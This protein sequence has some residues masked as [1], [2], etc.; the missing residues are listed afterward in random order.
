MSDQNDQFE[1]LYQRGSLDS[2]DRDRVWAEALRR[3][4]AGDSAASPAPAGRHAGLDGGPQ[5]AFGRPLR[6]R[7]AL[8]AGG[9]VA[10]AA[11]A[12]AAALVFA[13]IQP[14]AAVD[15]TNPVSA[16]APEPAMAKTE[17]PEPAATAVPGVN[18]FPDLT[19]PAADCAPGVAAAEL[20]TAQAQEVMG[21]ALDTMAAPDLVVSAQT[22][23]QPDRAS[24]DEWMTAPAA[25]NLLLVNQL[26]VQDPGGEPDWVGDAEDL[27]FAVKDDGTPYSTRLMHDQQ[28]YEVNDPE[29]YGNGVD[30]LD[31]EG[32]GWMGQ[33]TEYWQ[34]VKSLLAAA[35]APAAADSVTVLGPDQQD[36]R[37]VVKL[38]LGEALLPAAYRTSF[39]VS[40][41]LWLYLDDGMPARTVFTFDRAPIRQDYA[42]NLEGTLAVDVWLAGW[43]WEEAKVDQDASGTCAD[44]PVIYRW[45]RT[46][47]PAGLLALPIPEGYIEVDSDAGEPTRPS[48][49]MS[50]DGCVVSQS[51]DPETGEYVWATVCPGPDEILP[52]D[53]VE[54][55]VVSSEEELLQLRDAIEAAGDRVTCITVS[56]A[57]P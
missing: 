15:Q 16:T 30:Y 27:L 28:L 50:I 48:D 45:A 52:P 3:A 9:V 5:G 51:L 35:S 31:P 24:T 7:G 18:H 26:W 23:G 33:L 53:G 19:A 10:A 2:M 17:P 43:C 37:D 4:G 38:Q 46:D 14:R 1:R 25:G 21:C 6:R 22:V 39:A 57:E 13:A 32:P 56:L 54:C 47:D 41:E 36:G 11:V 20:T 40:A 8:L 34:R 44:S 29:E 49:V 12:A 55:A 42:E